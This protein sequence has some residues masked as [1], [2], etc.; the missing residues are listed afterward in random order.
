MASSDPLSRL[1]QQLAKLP[2]IGERTATR[3]AFH[4]LR[5]PDSYAERLSAAL[6]EVKRK[7]RQCSRCCMLTESDPCAICSDQ[8]RDAARV[9][10]VATPQ[11]ALAVERSGSYR[12]RYH[13]LHGL[14]S[15]LDGLG[16]DQLR[17]R[18][19]LA[20][21][22]G[23]D[24]QLQEA[25]LA[26]SPSVEGDATALYLARLLK[27]LGV[28]VTRIAS[29]VPIGSELEFADGVTLHRAIEERRRV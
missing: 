2:G 5:S 3:L 12:G 13:V 14:L 16:P 25:I 4:I 1:V 9:M 22:A 10:V 28:E 26:T 23:A 24:E 6:L 17:I 15:P 8:R 19:L 11:D 21:C 20:R 18:E 7:L 27:P 29:G